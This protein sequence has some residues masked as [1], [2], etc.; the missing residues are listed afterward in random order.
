[1]NQVTAETR[2][3]Y[4]QCAY[5]GC[6]T[7]SRDGIPGLKF[8]S[9]PVSDRDRCITWL[10]NSGIDDYVELSDSELK[11]IK[12]CS[13]H[14]SRA[15]FYPSGSIRKSAVPKLYPVPDSDVE[16]DVDNAPQDWEFERAQLL[17]R[18]KRQKR[19][20]AHLK[21]E[22]SELRGALKT[23]TQTIRRLTH[24][25]R[26]GII[27]NV[28]LAE[29]VARKVKDFVLTFV[30]MQIFHKTG[31]RYTEDEKQ[32][33]LKIHYT[34]P[35]LYS[36][37]R[38]EFNFRLPSYSTIKGWFGKVELW[39]GICPAMFQHLG[40]KVSSMSPDERNCVLLFDEVRIKKAFDLHDGKQK[41]EGFEDLGSFGCSS[42]VAT[43]ALVFMVRGLFH[44]WKQ[45]VAYFLSAGVVKSEKLMDI[46]HGILDALLDVGLRVRATVC[47]QGTHNQSS[48]FAKVSVDHPFFMHRG[49][50]IFCFFD[51][52]HL[53]KSL[54]NQLWAHDFMIS[55]NVRVSWTDLELLWN[56]EHDKGTRAAYKLSAKHVN[57]HNFDRMKC[58]LAFQVFSRKVSAALFT[59]AATGGIQSETVSATASFF[60]TLNDLFDN[61]N[62]R[63][64]NDANPNKCAISDSRP[65]VEEN[66]R[67]Q[68]EACKS[69]RTITDKGL[70]VPPCFTGLILSLN[71]VLQLWDDLKLEGTKFLLTS[72]LNQDPLENLFSM[73]RMHGGTYDP[74]PS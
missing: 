34:S 57:P 37:M 71:A 15:D 25:L 31:N 18:V 29:A 21:Q 65:S 12:I 49:F 6:G 62:S 61:L 47:D 73:I 58:S 44:N 74:N 35:S 69:W 54:R 4:A 7:R 14:F 36:K 26:H 59:A 67:K 55:D 1:M 66:L 72:R 17:T 40:T 56:L 39:P 46:L 23:K 10:V 48:I 5:I 20:I 52:P 27:S 2:T 41:I 9:I 43:D 70:K 22:N 50:K 33:A 8:F 13:R 53:G 28:A 38:S 45:P 24:R 42:G 11:K 16:M 60:W 30:M 51:W 3:H 68:L 32:I 64:A 19:I 63:S